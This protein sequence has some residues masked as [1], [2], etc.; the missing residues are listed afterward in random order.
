MKEST[1][2]TL[3]ARRILVL[4]GAMGTMIQ[5]LRLSE[6]DYRGERFRDLPAERQLRGNNDIL[7][8]TLPGAVEDIHRAYLESGADIVETNTFNSTAVSQKEY[9]LSELAYELSRAGAEIARRAADAYTAR[10]PER[11]RFAAGVLGPTSKTLSL[12]PDVANPGYREIDFHG[13][14]AAYGEAAR[15]LL[16]GG[17]D[18]VLIETVFDTLN[19]KAAIFALK[20]LF[21]RRGACVPV[22][23]SGTITDASGRTLSGQTPAAFCHSVAHADAFSVGLNC[24]LGADLLRP[25]LEEIAAAAET[26][27]SLHP[28]AGL[29]NEFGGYDH[30]PELMARVLGDYARE[31]LLNIVGGCCG[32]TPEHIRAIADAVAGAA[33]R[34]IPAPRHLTSFAGLEPLELR[35]DSLFVNIGERTNVTGSA[36]FRRLVTEGRHEEALGVAREQVENGAQI[37]DVNMDEAMLDSA[38]EMRIFLNLLAAEPDIARVPVMIDSSRWDVIEAGLACVQGKGIVNSISLKEG[39]EEFLRRAELVRRYGAAA[40]VMAFDEKGQADTLERRINICRRAFRLLTEKA[41]FPPEDIILDANVFA[42]GTGLD[43]HRNY[44]VDFLEAVRVV[45]STLPFV[46]TSGGISN[47]SFSFRGNETVRRAMHSAFL[48]HAIRA[49]LDMGIVNSGQLDVYDEIPKP[50]LEAVEDVILNRRPDA[51]ERLLDV[52][53]GTEDAGGPGGK[54]AEDPAW[55]GLPVRERLSHALV[56]GITAFIEA[57]VE[58]ARREIGRA[59]PVIEGPLMDGMN[60]VGA[61]FGAGKMFLPQVVKSARVMKQAV[62]YLEPFIEAEKAADASAAAEAGTAER[63]AAAPGDRPAG[64]GLFVIATVKGDVHDIGKNIVKVVLQCNGWEVVDLGVMTPARDILKAARDRKADIVGL[65][66]LITPSLDEMVHVAS[67]LEREGFT[68]PLLVGGA[69]TSE[70][71]TAFKIEPAYSGPVLH[72]KDASLAVGAAARLLDP[73]TRE[74]FA[75]E[76]RARYAEARRRRNAAP[77]ADFIPLADARSRRFDPGWTGFLPPRPKKPGIHVFR[78]VPLE[79]LARYIDWS[80]FFMAWEMD[81]K[82][83]EVLDHPEKGEEARILLRDARAM[84]ARMSRERLV[85]ARGVLGLLPAAADEDDTVVVYRDEDRRET[86]LRIPFLRQQRRKTEV[87]YYL[88]LADYVAPAGSGLSDWIGFFAVT[89]GIGLDGVV[90][91]FEAEGDDYGAIMVKVL[92]DRLAEAFAEYIHLLARRDHWGYAPDE[93]LPVED[94]LRVRYRGIRPAPGYPPC[95]DHRDK[96]LIWKLLE[97]DARAGIGLTESCMMT[98]EASVSGYIFSH[99]EAKY[100]S[101]DKLARDQV[102]DYARRKGDTLAVAEKW[103]RPMLGY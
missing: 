11:P 103:L 5:G 63:S 88:S 38:R 60:A 17:A 1:L 94:L 39:E 4:D 93:N 28:N 95:P 45:K 76:I 6:D 79:T 81:G 75:A 90:R 71:H 84:L 78:E 68:T 29:P 9:G 37:I 72:V 52:A 53:A 64:K 41:G 102:E 36:R 62:M 91:K 92:S 31:G 97:P 46:K 51:T 73:R 98:P 16:D 25:Y 30:S 23:I 20:E 14:A 19:A 69:T 99:P 49:G 65:S 58:E 101:V 56:K 43:E 83:P 50:L 54:A 18:L 33:P 85:E 77:P 34:P 32:T 44:A 59:L 67:E 7:N 21:A 87:P 66:G 3:L 55:R 8:L 100:F 27:V 89:A 2:K 40:V 96:L 61:L 48:Y 70:I 47:L 35:P 74:T 15:G 12:S 22:M 10:D 57:D 82:Y 80:F 42:V 24:A 86:L 13:L 26:A